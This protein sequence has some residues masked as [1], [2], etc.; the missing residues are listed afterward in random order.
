MLIPNLSLEATTLLSRSG[1]T[2]V[3]P[4]GCMPPA[5]CSRLAHAKCELGGTSENV[6]TQLASSEVLGIEPINTKLRFSHLLKG[7]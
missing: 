4:S 5:S 3:S 7:L 6:Q 1:F 2:Y